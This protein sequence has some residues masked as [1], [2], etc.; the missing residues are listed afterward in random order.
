MSGEIRKAMVHV[1]GVA[2][3]TC[4]MS[5]PVV[6]RE[7]ML[8][9]RIGP[10]KMSVYIANADGSNER[11]LLP[12]ST[13]LDYDASFSPDGQWI[14]FT[15]ERDAAGN[16]QADIWRVRPDG[17]GLERLTKD[18]SMEDAAALS[19]DGKSVAFV[20]TKGGARTANIWIMDV[21]SK[22][23]RN[24]T[25]DGKAQ[26][27]ATMNGYFRPSWSPDGKWIAFS[28]DRGEGWIGAESG[29]GAGHSHPTSLYVIRPDGSGMRRLTSTTPQS[30]FGTPRWSADGRKLVSYEVPT[31]ETFGARM[32]GFGIAALG[33]TS[34][35]VEI[36][37]ESGERKVLTSGAGLKTNPSYL[38][39]T[40]VGYLVKNSGRDG[41]PEKG[42]TYSDGAMG[43]KGDV[44]TPSWSPDGSM[45]VYGR[46]DT[47]NRDHWTQLY[48]WD[49]KREYRYT[50]VFPAVCEKTQRI[51]QTDLNFPFGNPTASLTV[52]NI[53]GSDRKM[54]F[55]RQDAASL[56]PTWSP[57]CQSVAVGVGTFFGGRG[58]APANVF[59]VKADGS[60]NRQL[61]QNTVNSGYP[62]WHP[63]GKTLIYR[64][65]GTED[66]PEKRGLRALD[67]STNAT[68]VLTTNWDNFP[69]VSPTGDR[70]VFTRRMPSFDFEVF[71]MKP[72]GTDVKQ[73]TSTPGADA[74]ATWSADG[75]EIWFSSSRSGFKDEAAMFD[76]SPQ[77]YA[78][79]YLMKRDGTQVRQVTDSKWEDSMGTYVRAP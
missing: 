19:P 66:V 20:S 33:A 68:K 62:A 46:F 4:V 51:A 75:K 13:G 64:V 42:V 61:T 11:R 10:S 48:S 44:R 30:S 60:E 31:R 21:A 3:A 35:I 70:V 50:D 49:K 5:A 41:K 6:A 12:D 7:V 43:P 8:M 72:D 71:T 27:P 24:L 69:F 45:V 47:K 67:M 9:N 38:A 36:D 78:Q 16:G 53:D 54:I 73:L 25:G 55:Q 1:M 65:W 2:M 37:V 52:M 63:D 15:S 22:R 56:M 57:D 32:H 76:I 40:R 39:G 28:S 29:A 18:T 23:A 79:V 58:F 59:V 14:V 77:P 17:T 34:Q 26:S 74:H